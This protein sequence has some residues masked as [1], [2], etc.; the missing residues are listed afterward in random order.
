M[1]ISANYPAIRPSLLLDF[2]NSKV[3]DPRITFSR[4]T[5]ATYYNGITTA[6]AEQNLLQY[7]QVFNGGGW[8][9]GFVTVVDNTAVAPDGTTTAAL[10]YPTTSGNSKGL[11]INGA[12]IPTS[13]TIT[14]SI[15]AK[16]SGITWFCIY[17]PDTVNGAAWFNLSTGAVGTV[18]VGWTATITSVGNSWYRCSVTGPAGITYA[19]FGYTD[20]DN[21]V[22]ATTS[23]TNGVLLWGSQLE[24]RSSM[25]AY[26]VTTNLPI[27]N[28]ISVLLTAPTNTARFDHNPTTGESLGLLI[29][30][31]RTNLLTYSDDFA[32]AA[33]TKG[34]ASITSNTIIAPDG[35]L[36]GDALVEDTST[37]AH[38]INRAVTVSNTTIYTFTIYA[39]PN[40]RSWIIIQLQ[41]GTFAYVNISTGAVGGTTGSPT[42]ATTSVGNGWYR[43]SITG[44]SSSTSITNQIYLA[45]ADGTFSYA[46]NG[47]S[48]VFI[49]GAQLE[50]GAFATSYIPTVASQVTRSADS[51]SMTGTNFSSW[52]NNQQ[53]SFYAEYDRIGINQFSRVFTAVDSGGSNAYQIALLNFSSITAETAYIVAT[54]STTMATTIGTVASVNTS[55]KAVV[56][57]QSGNSGAAFNGT[58]ITSNTNSFNVLVDRLGIG[59]LVGAN[60]QY[61]NGHIKKLAYYPLRVTNAQLQA[62][63]GS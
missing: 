54:G 52:Y 19:Q 24:A 14:T 62:L 15:F 21:S 22:T 63:T 17:K 60:I 3:L 48:G 1:P 27:T 44:T 32:N 45:T 29:E 35:T 4:P 6:I 57:Y 18:A 56:S 46:G 5:T 41:S 40:G 38:V 37:G 51:A 26:T 31:Q 39:K 33:W 53:G 61:V 49:W 36:I 12:S 10:V 30:E 42:V 8:N 47:Y 28:Y 13:G 50:A 2:A 55:S 16:A 34:A 7:S 59:Y 9:R 25:T 43:V 23:G 58:A 20:A 11:Y